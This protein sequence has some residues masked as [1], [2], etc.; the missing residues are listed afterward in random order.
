M[1]RIV[2]EM[3]TRRATARARLVR[4][5]LGA[6]VAVAFLVL[7]CSPA[8]AQEEEGDILRGPRF[9]VL[10]SL[11]VG[12]GTFTSPVHGLPSFI[13]YSVL[14]LEMAYDTGGRWGGFLR[15]TFLSSGD[16]GRWTSPGLSLGATYRLQG[17]GETQFGYLLRG[18]LIYQRWHASLSGCDVP[19]LYPE[20]CQDQTPP[21][22]TGVITAPVNNYDTT[23][24]TGGL[25]AG[26]RAELP[27][28]P[29][30]VA[31]GAEVAGTVDFTQASPGTVWTGM[32]T[33]TLGLR[34]HQ[35]DT[36]MHPPS[37]NGP[38]QRTR[39]W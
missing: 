6:G 15:G 16:D 39:G 1:V 36:A 10:P 21:P 18:G 3:K 4:L 23:I 31:F 26:I 11:G 5:G 30:Y 35:T 28:V 22:Q 34:N 7:L 38:R 33:I 19:F 8:R 25:F 24:D 37:T 13:G 9:E 17:D 32:L 2:H 20:S 27:L 12:M 14:S 29:Y